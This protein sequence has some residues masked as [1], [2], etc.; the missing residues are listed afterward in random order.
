MTT[1]RNIGETRV[2]TYNTVYITPPPEAAFQGRSLDH[3]AGANS[4]KTERYL[5]GKLSARGFQRR[6]FWHRHYS[7]CGDTNHGIQY[8]AKGGVIHTVVRG[9]YPESIWCSHRGRRLDPQTHAPLHSRH[10]VAHLVCA[11]RGGKRLRDA[12][13]HRTSQH[14]PQPASTLP[15][16]LRGSIR[17]ITTLA[18]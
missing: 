18:A 16:P 12:T 11:P 13:Q 3:Q 2:Y 7:K 10:E 17:T 8:R 14:R 5:F 9:R 1:P 4:V 6:L 15:L